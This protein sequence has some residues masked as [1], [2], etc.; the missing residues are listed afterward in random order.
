M[1]PNELLAKRKKEEG[2][3]IEKRYNWQR[4]V[5]KTLYIVIFNFFK[6]LIKLKLSYELDKQKKELLLI[7]LKEDIEKYN[8]FLD[9][10]FTK[11]VS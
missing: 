8:S 5:T 6:I 10:Y 1:P 4:I 11:I 3:S 7:K 2:K 9:Q